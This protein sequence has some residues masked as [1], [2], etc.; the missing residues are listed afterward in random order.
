MEQL[1][2]KSRGFVIDEHRQSVDVQNDN[3]E[4]FNGKEDQH[5]VYH[6]KVY[7][8]GESDNQERS[9]LDEQ[10]FDSAPDVSPEVG[11]TRRRFRVVLGRQV[12]Y[13]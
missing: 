3:Q 9:I 6:V 7:H 5:L 8:N 4:I 2:V 13:C 11:E 1:G 10:S 12:H